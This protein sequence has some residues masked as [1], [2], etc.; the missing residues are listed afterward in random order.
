MTWITGALTICTTLF[1]HPAAIR[2]IW[3]VPPPYASSKLRLCRSCRCLSAKRGS[4]LNS[5]PVVST[6]L[7]VMGIKDCTGR[8][9]GRRNPYNV[10]PV[11]RRLQEWSDLVC[12][13]GCEHWNR[14][15]KHASIVPGRLLRNT[16]RV[17]HPAVSASN[18]AVCLLHLLLFLLTALDRVPCA[19]RPRVCRRCGT[20]A[21]QENCLS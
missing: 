6:V 1:L 11:S 10:V 4:G 18:A 8:V 19:L 2:R 13:S 9:I 17:P 21:G 20:Q 14:I 12:Q 15:R 7:E 16:L 5:N 3:R